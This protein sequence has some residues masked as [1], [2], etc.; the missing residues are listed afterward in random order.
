M[1]GPII[2]NFIPGSTVSDMNSA[3]FDLGVCWGTVNL[4]FA[5]LVFSESAGLP[6]TVPPGAFAGCGITYKNGYASDS[7]KFYKEVYS[8]LPE[9]DKKQFNPN[10]DPGNNPYTR[11]LNVGGPCFGIG[12]SGILNEM[13]EAIHDAVQLIANDFLRIVTNNVSNSGSHYSQVSG[14]TSP[15][16]NGINGQRTFDLSIGDFQMPNI[17]LMQFGGGCGAGV[18]YNLLFIGNFPSFMGEFNRNEMMDLENS[19]ELSA[20]ATEGYFISKLLGH[21][22]HVKQ[23]AKAVAII[24]DAAMGPIFPGLQLSFIFS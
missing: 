20:R 3:C 9:Q 16:L 2:L 14:S 8:K 19:Y 15:L 21:L 17:L 18:N 23:Q 6:F 12:V 11:K 10:P 7:E 4:P 5:P 22:L 1:G 24:P 13:G